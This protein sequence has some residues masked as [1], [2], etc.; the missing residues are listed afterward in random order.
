MPETVRFEVLMAMTT[1][2][3]GVTPYSLLEVSE[4]CTASIF[5]IEE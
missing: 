5:R 4:E 3:W 1:N 2:F